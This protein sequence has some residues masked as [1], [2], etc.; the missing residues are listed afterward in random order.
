MIDYDPI[1][2]STLKQILPTY[3]E[4]VLTS[5]KNT[6][7]ISYQQ[8]NNADDVTGDTIGY[9]RLYY[10]IKVWSNDKKE[11]NKYMLLIDKALRPLGFTRTS[12]NELGDRSSTMRQKIM[13]YEAL[14]IENY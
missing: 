13:Q 12:T 14:A 3:D 4:L 8:L 6:P 7:C 9:S 11:L 10:T 1:I 2:V 5:N